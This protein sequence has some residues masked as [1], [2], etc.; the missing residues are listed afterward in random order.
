MVLYRL[1]D[2][3]HTSVVMSTVDASVSSIGFGKV[4]KLERWWRV[5]SQ[6]QTRLGVLGLLPYQKTVIV[7]LF[8][9]TNLQKTAYIWD[10]RLMVYVNQS[11]LYKS[12]SGTKEVRSCSTVR[13]CVNAL[14]S[15]WHDWLFFTSYSSNLNFGCFPWRLARKFL[16]FNIIWH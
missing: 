11:E 8:R 16:H 3:V 6:T 13:I 15:R 4:Y 10:L 9:P 7:Y 1:S 12:W 2:F 14:T 5:P